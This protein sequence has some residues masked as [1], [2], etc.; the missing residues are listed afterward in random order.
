M[1]GSISK[2]IQEFMNNS[3]H[4]EPWKKYCPDAYRESKE[5]I[6][7]FE[8]KLPTTVKIQLDQNMLLDDFCSFLESKRKILRNRENIYFW[9][10][11]S[12]KYDNIYHV[13]SDKGT[14][15][16]K[17]TEYPVSVSFKPAQEA[18]CVTIEIPW[19]QQSDKIYVL[20]LPSFEGLGSLLRKGLLPPD[21]ALGEV[22]Q[23]QTVNRLLEA[24]NVAQHCEVRVK[25]LKTLLYNCGYKSQLQPLPMSEFFFGKSEDTLTSN[26][27]NDLKPYAV[28]MEIEKLQQVSCLYLTLK[29]APIPGILSYVTKEKP[30]SLFWSI[31]SYIE[32]HVECRVQLTSEG[33]DIIQTPDSHGLLNTPWDAIGKDTNLS[34]VSLYFQSRRIKHFLQDDDMEDIFLTYNRIATYG[35][36]ARLELPVH[37]DA[38]L[39]KHNTNILRG[40]NTYAEYKENSTICSYLPDE[41]FILSILHSAPAIANE[42][43]RF[44]ENFFPHT[45]RLQILHY[46]HVSFPQT[47]FEEEE[48]ALLEGRKLLMFTLNYY[49][50][51]AVSPTTRFAETC[52]DSTG[53]EICT[54]YLEN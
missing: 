4:Y 30:F 37:Y 23:L 40:C 18:Q 33:I 49:R 36:D 41:L 13:A 39:P 16:L 2:Q 53:S 24:S 21:N 20:T 38:M 28:L 35:P 46:L 10:D 22:G 14:K 5:P 11:A 8:S 25:N 27:E 29:I 51:R 15:E 31:Q 45:I 7:S 12:P 54:N 26:L 48:Q 9:V 34:L 43:L 44:H 47:T 52:V 6:F 42:K 3:Y 50:P 19:I 17:G 32:Q 1:S